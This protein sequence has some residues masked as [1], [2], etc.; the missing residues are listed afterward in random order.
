[1]V[2]RGDN[3][4]FIVNYLGTHRGAGSVEVR[5]ALAAHN[6]KAWRPGLY[7]WYFNRIGIPGIHRPRGVEL[8]LWE[9]LVRGWGLTTAGVRHCI[10][11][12]MGR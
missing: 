10:A 3:I 12:S 6:G 2:K 4:N 8:G 11:K 7:C 9:P 5:K 1:M